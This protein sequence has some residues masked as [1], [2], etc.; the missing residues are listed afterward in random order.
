MSL[1]LRFYTDTLF[2]K[3]K[4]RIG[5]TCSQIFTHEDFF[6]IIPMRSKSED[7][8]TPDRIN[9]DAGLENEITMDNAPN[10]TG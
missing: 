10:Q 9:R 3:E 1:N 2:A 7:G 8:T 5:N 6:Q 4:Y